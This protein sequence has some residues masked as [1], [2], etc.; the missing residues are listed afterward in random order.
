[1]NENDI[2]TLVLDCAFKIHRNLG[3]G[4]L[5][6]V[7]ESVLDQQLRDAGLE[8]RRQAPIDIVYNGK[9][10]NEGFVADLIIENK[11][12]LELKSVEHVSGV[13]KK[14]LLTYLRLT[15]I[16]LGYILNFN[17]DLMKNGIH[18]TINGTLSKLP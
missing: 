11:V 7:Y 17:T 6:R 13:H 15:N 18:R 5:E 4:L 8:V 10:F 12:I 14:Q 16:K 2:G 3:P 9:Q 1:M